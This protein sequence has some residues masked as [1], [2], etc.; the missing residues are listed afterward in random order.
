MK[1]IT[2]HPV[3]EDLYHIESE[4]GDATHYDY[5]AFDDAGTF[6]FCAAK[7]SIRYPATL[8]YWEVRNADEENINKL[9]VREHCNPWTVAECA[10][11]AIFIAEGNCPDLFVTENGGTEAEPWPTFGMHYRS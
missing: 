4:P 11:A 1:R 9:A 2:I 7:S 5:I 8:D 3:S 10:R 6:H